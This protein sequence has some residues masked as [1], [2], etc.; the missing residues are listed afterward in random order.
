ML[1]KLQ[2]PFRDNFQYLIL[3]LAQI[4]RRTESQT[5]MNVLNVAI[6]FAPN[7]FFDYQRGDEQV[8]K[9]ILEFGDRLWE[10]SPQKS[11]E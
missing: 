2:Q 11:S 6:V 7:I 4:I 8:L 9:F 3:A 1:S 10:Q 5:K